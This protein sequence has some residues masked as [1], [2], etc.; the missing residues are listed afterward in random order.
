[1]PARILPYD[2]G[3]LS[4]LREIQYPLA[5]ATQEPLAAI[6]VPT[7]Q[8]QRDDWQVILLK[9]IAILD[10][11]AKAQAAVDKADQGI[12]HF[13]GRVSRAIDDH[14]DG[15]TRK[16]IRTALFKNKALSKFR[17]PVLGGQLQAQS[18]W[19]DTL[20]KCGV[21]AL[22]AL[23]P[24]ADT[25]VA[26]GNAATLLRDTAQQANRV[27]RD[28]GERKQFIDKLNASRKEIHGALAKLPFE[29]P[30]LPQ[31][32]ADGFFYSEAP[33]D[34]E[35]T[36]DEVKTSIE[37]LKAQ[38]ETRAALLKKLED[39][40]ENAAR[41]EQERLAQAQTAE[42]LEAQA[43]ALLEKAAALKSKAKK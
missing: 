8:S 28:V 32:F 38:L 33:R 37:E 22:A 7:F 3:L 31:D 14:T 21:P 36:I 27:F 2:V 34:Q 1:M 23:A 43:K 12:D 18:D 24:E 10:D 41:D 4:L 17:R 5:R 13:A 39:E 40:A 16:Q 15:H 25:H 19:S 35:E 9:E 6:Y 11:L 20:S 26:A 30:N 42:D 29:H